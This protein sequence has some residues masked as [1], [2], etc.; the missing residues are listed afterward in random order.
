MVKWR[1]YEKK[2]RERG[3]E[4]CREKR[5][6]GGRTREEMEGDKG[7]EGLGGELEYK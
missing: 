7:G 3:E 1:I 2:E 6:R 5:R 4:K